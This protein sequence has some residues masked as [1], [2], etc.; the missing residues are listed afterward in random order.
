MKAVSGSNIHILIN[1]KSHMAENALEEYLGYDFGGYQY[2]HEGLVLRTYGKHYL[3]V[4]SEWAFQ[5][6][7]S[8]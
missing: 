1:H 5:Q 6:V 3:L 2:I 8:E 4:P 7:N